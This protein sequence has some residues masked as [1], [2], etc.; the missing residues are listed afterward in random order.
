M[1][2]WLFSLFVLFS[3]YAWPEDVRLPEGVAPLRYDLSLEV[4][5]DQESFSGTARITLK[6][7]EQTKSIWLH[8][9]ELHVKQAGL[10]LHDGTR[11]AGKYD[12][13]KE[14]GTSRID[15]A[16]TISP[17]T[18]TLEIVYSAPFNS[19]LEGLY[20]IEDEKRWYAFTQFEAISARLCF[21]GFDEPSFK[22]PFDITLT[23]PGDHSA[24]TNTLPVEE[25]PLQ[26]GGKRIRFAT[27]KELPTYLIAIAVGPFDVVSGPD[28]P[29]TAVRQTPVPLRAVAVRGKGSRLQYALQNTGGILT[30]LEEYFGIAYPFEKLDLIAVP[31]FDWGA[32]ENAGAITFRESLLVI[33]EQTASYDQKKSFAA[34]MAH[35]VAHHW[36]GDLVTM[37]WWDD[38]WLNEGLTSWID[39]RVVEM[40]N[41]SYKAMV[42][43]V[44]SAR[45]IMNSDSSASAKAVYRRV[46]RTPDIM[47]IADGI[48]FAKGA[49]IP[50]MFEGYMGEKQFQEFIRYYVNQHRFSNATSEDFLKALQKKADN[51]VASA[52]RSFLM[53]PGVPFLQV[54]STCSEGKAWV[55][56]HQSRYA[57]LGVD[58]K[59]PFSWKVPVCFRFE[60]AGKMERKC[61]I[62]S[63]DESLQLTESGCPAWI[64]P[65]ADGRGYY[66]WNL[67]PQGWTDLRR[68]AKGKIK[69]EE[70]LSIV[71]SVRASFDSG[72]LS[73][74]D[75]LQAL[76]PYASSSI[77]ELAMAPSTLLIFV[78]DHIAGSNGAEAIRQLGQRAYLP[79]YEQLGFES[80]ANDSNETKQFRKEVVSFLVLEAKHQEIR[81]EAAGKGLE[82]V[83]FGKDGKLH[84]EVVDPNL[85]EIVLSAALQEYG[86]EFLE[87]VTGILLASDDSLLR[88]Q[89]LDAIGRVTE[90]DAVQRVL[91]LSL[92][93]AL[94]TNEVLSPTQSLMLESE[95]REAVWQWIRENY[96]PLKA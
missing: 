78:R 52:F 48:I 80:K 95:N 59:D 40:W 8:G 34:V 51:E 89:I 58:F 71:D 86:S 41:P 61:E 14:D 36:F 76:I 15:L 20:R 93:P 2:Q 3:V 56:V 65:D 73:T 13:V 1:K 30:V 50:L 87:E 90:A 46:E 18:G 39:N 88:S 82:Y 81:K 26:N 7:L 5:P 22:T 45:A 74:N 11:V 83:G 42:A 25:I 16:Q 19:K 6:I 96:E 92:N 64:M 55:R 44:Q 35:E 24:I 66:R 62:F 54:E 68:N 70:E 23:I 12:Q 29:A 75:A 72:R 9:K 33:D 4:D 47:S 28:I 85:I 38:I 84:P 32:M 17:Q 69:V 94:R 57:P 67:S 79:V 21:P 10:E 27:T 37:S 63:Q 43:A 77:R 60:A 31:D 53:Q 49:A 91:A